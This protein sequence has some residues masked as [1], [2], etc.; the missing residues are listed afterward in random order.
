[1]GCE[2]GD[3]ASAAIVPSEDQG[4]IDGEAPGGQL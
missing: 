1:M 3:L 2:M 4:G